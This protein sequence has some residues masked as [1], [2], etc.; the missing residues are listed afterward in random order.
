MP[1]EHPKRA[2]SDKSQCLGYSKDHRRCRLE[3]DADSKTCSIH[4]NYYR[5]WWTK[6]Y[7]SYG[8]IDWASSRQR[9][10]YEFQLR[11]GH[12]EVPDWYF[13]RLRKGDR[14]EYLW[15]I[16]VAKCNPLRNL[17]LFYYVILCMVDELLTFY[18][19]EKERIRVV[20]S[21]FELLLQ[22]P[23]CCQEA[24]SVLLF[25][26]LFAYKHYNHLI[27]DTRGHMFWYRTFTFVKSWTQ[28]LKS[29]VL[30]ECIAEFRNKLDTMG[31]TF[32]VQEDGV[33]WLEDGP[34][35]GTVEKLR[36]VLDTVSNL[37]NNSM[38]ERA[39]ILRHNGQE[40]K[41]ELVAIAFAPE[42]V[43]RLLDAGYE[44]EDL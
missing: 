5:D 15:L 32:L 23:K 43:A 3:R 11:N 12:T 19:L 29:S 27:T 18:S 22:T 38:A 14:K 39:I 7:R 1:K 25:R 9:A 36:S 13:A 8:N 35:S 2:A 42:R 6:T 10:E 16:Q 31:M 28:L 34:T 20:V 41:R 26:T 21:E 30:H 44:I 17:E 37:V 40:L 24:F 4:R 33:G